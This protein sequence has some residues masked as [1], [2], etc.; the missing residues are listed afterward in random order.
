MLFPKLNEIPVSRSVIDTFRGYNHN[1]RIGA[2]EF[3]DMKNMTGDDYPVLSPRK[4]RGIF[5]D[6][7]RP[8][9][10][11]FKDALYYTAG[12]K[13]YRHQA[14]GDDSEYDLNF[15]EPADGAQKK[16]ISFG[17]YII[18]LPDKK[19]FN[20][21]DETYGSCDAAFHA[22]DAAVGVSWC[23]EDGTEYDTV[24]ADAE[25]PS[26]P[27]NGAVWLDTTQS[28]PVLKMWYATSAMW[29]VISP[30][31]L[32]ITCS[33]IGGEF[34]VGDSVSIH[35]PTNSPLRAIF[36]GRDYEITA[37]DESCLVVSGHM[38]G[39]QQVLFGQQLIVS[40]TMPVMDFCFEHENRL[41]GCRY[42]VGANGEFVNEIYASKLGD[43][44]NWKNFRGVST[45]SFSA[46]CGTDGKWT[47]AVKALGYPL[48]FK[49][50][51]LHKVYGSYPAEYQI[52][53][54]PCRGV[55]E[56]C[57][58]SLAVVNEALF[59]KSR[60]GV[61]AYDGSLPTCVSDALGNAQYGEAVAC[62]CGC[63]YYISMRDGNGAWSLFCYDTQKGFWHREDSLRVDAFCVVGDELLYME[64][65]AQR[66]GAMSGKDGTSQEKC[67]AWYAETGILGADS[68]D[69][70]YL[71]RITVRLSMA[72]GTRVKFFAEYDSCGSWQTL[73]SVTGKSLNSFSVPLRPKRCDHLRLRIE[74]EGAA[75]IFSIT[76]TT[77][78]GSDIR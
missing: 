17:A 45:D 9:G 64:H 27:H 68:P 57:E 31:Y 66:I 59:Y 35:V 36:G 28:E 3:Y 72:L 37:K 55:Q 67:M 40:R 75:K 63:K 70:K 24:L 2:G 6:G 18:I 4:S 20:T 54:I 30:T 25:E 61:C 51:Y 74:G 26:E 78:Q 29:A 42:G 5:I 8:S 11:L 21:A 47:G 49:E 7:I 53:T 41:W 52:Q 33:G 19:W 58:N 38:R 12:T 56:G 39:V 73:A 15:S 76:M 14:D 44:K 34:D 23:R 13:L 48:F 16:L 10:M 46:S 62:G 77:E 1:L 69:H 50:N 60:G 43:F 22:N 65:D 32:K 71:S